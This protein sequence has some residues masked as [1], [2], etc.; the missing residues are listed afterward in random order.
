MIDYVRNCA[1]EVFSEMGSGH[2]EAVYE[3]C[4]ALELSHCNTLYPVNITR[5][6]PCP[7]KYKGFTIGVGFI[8][9]M[10]D[11]LVVELKAVSKITPK[12]VQQVRKYLEALDL[13]N[14]LL[15]NFGNDLEIVEVQK[16][17]NNGETV[18]NEPIA[19]NS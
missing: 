7:L 15:I 11:G 2:T 9:I 12:D 3:A 13:E 18:N 5:Q 16:V 6:V 17:G 10:V 1:T 4:M 19:T 14:G 8:D